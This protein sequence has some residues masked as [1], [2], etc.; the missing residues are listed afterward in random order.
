M[1]Y[2]RVLPTDSLVCHLHFLILLLI[3]MCRIMSA[4]VREN[5]LFSHAFDPEFYE[6]VLDGV[7]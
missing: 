3:P 6:I 1:R 5:I 7:L 4:T 2:D